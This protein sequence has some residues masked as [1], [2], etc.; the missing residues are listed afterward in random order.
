M[1]AAGFCLLTEVAIW[2][3]EKGDKEA[4]RLWNKE[5]GDSRLTRV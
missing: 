1:R 5:A 2:D 4:R 3:Q